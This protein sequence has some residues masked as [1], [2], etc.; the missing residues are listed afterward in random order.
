MESRQ[1]SL[2]PPS[3]PNEQAQ[4]FQLQS[5]V[6]TRQQRTATEQQVVPAFIEPI[7]EPIT[8]ADGD[9]YEQNIEDDFK[10]Q[11]QPI[12]Q[13]Y[14]NKTRRLPPVNFFLD[15]SPMIQY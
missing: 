1:G 5:Q 4:Q 15:M 2:L 6:R 7:S 14:L 10:V 13:D 9:K 12:L 3:P 8:S 11:I